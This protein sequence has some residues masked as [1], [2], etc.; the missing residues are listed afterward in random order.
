MLMLLFTLLGCDPTPPKELADTTGTDTADSVPDEECVERRWFPDEDGDGYGANTQ[1]IEAC[2]APDGHVDSSGDCDDSD[3]S[4]YPGAD[5]VCSCGDGVDNDSDGLSDC[6]DGDCS[7]SPLC[8]EADCGGYGDSDGDGLAG[9]FDD[10]C[11]GS[12]ACGELRALSTVL[13]GQLRVQRS[14]EYMTGP[15]DIMREFRTGADLAEAQEVYG[16]VVFPAGGAR[17]STASAWTSCTWAV[18]SARV[19]AR[20][21]SSHPT[22]VPGD[23]LR[24]GFSLEDGCLLST[25]AF[26]PEHLYIDRSAVGPLL[27]ERGGG[28]GVWTW[29]GGALTG[30]VSSLW[31]RTTGS[32]VSSTWVFSYTT[33]SR[34]V[35]LGGGDPFPW[36]E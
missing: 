17:W 21:N 22:C 14:L 34:S 24:E 31:Q 23:T 6:E 36:M 1:P 30:T 32:S 20:W 29:Y 16:T 28:C 35:A 3:A 33:V 12:A 15:R 26:L 25:S 9:C 7:E 19:F 27:E 11:W 5:E 8:A 4:V 2:E 18:Q 10:D 13:G